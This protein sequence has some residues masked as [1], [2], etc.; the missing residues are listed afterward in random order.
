M[1]KT[2]KPEWVSSKI[3]TETKQ[4]T[5]K[6][7]LG[8]DIT[9]KHLETNFFGLKYLPQ[10]EDE[11]YLQHPYYTQFPWKRDPN[12][13][14]FYG[15]YIS[16][17]WNKECI[18]EF[19]EENSKSLETAIESIQNLD[20]IVEIGVYRP[21]DPKHFSS[22]ETI[23]RKKKKECIYLGIDLVDKSYLDN[24]DQ[25]TFTI[26]ENSHNQEILRS[27]FEYFGISKI[28]LLLIDG[29]HSIN[30]AINDWLYADLVPVGGKII[31]H[32]TNQ[33]TGPRELMKAIDT[34]MF[35]VEFTCENKDSN[36]YHDMGLG[37]ITRIK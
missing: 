16:L 30:M 33:H 17:F 14:D 37:I 7:F 27:R 11:A 29:D 31:I 36:E 13:E 32:D 2:K 34:N 21:V 19:T 20:T 5:F 26:I 10:I 15:P 3:K 6:D 25:N 8:Q 23:I 18:M 24:E 35:D 28:D 22:T 1:E 9:I 12:N 4:E